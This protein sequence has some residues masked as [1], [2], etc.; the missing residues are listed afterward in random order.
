VL[1]CVPV[2]RDCFRKW[3]N[4]REA[5]SAVDN[6]TLVPKLSPALSAERTC[7]TTANDFQASQLVGLKLGPPFAAFLQQAGH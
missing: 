2:L 1:L 4:I 3:N 7:S 5:L 6:I